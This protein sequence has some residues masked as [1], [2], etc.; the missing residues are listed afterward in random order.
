M[1]LPVLI[2]DVSEFMQRIVGI[3][4]RTINLEIQRARSRKTEEQGLP[5]PDLSLRT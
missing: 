5:A 4:G 3:R 1:L 2:S